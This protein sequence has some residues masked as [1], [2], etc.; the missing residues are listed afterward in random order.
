VR[1]SFARVEAG[2]LPSPMDLALLALVCNVNYLGYDSVE[3]GL[4]MDE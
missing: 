1:R 4:A 3:A 2:G